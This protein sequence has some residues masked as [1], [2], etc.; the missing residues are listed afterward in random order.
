MVA[1]VLRLVVALALALTPVAMV[2]AMASQDGPA[3]V[4]QGMADCPTAPQFSPDMRCAHYC[5]AGLAA[6]D[7]VSALAGVGALELR[8]FSHRAIG[9]GIEPRVADPPPR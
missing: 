9:A 7:A 4:Q 2:G 6:S 5:F 1:F 8:N 3:A